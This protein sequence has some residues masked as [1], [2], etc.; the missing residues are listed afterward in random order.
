MNDK[1]RLI[2]LLAKSQS[3][4]KI[5]QLV[6]DDVPTEVIAEINSVSQSEFSKAAQIGITSEFQISMWSGEYAGQEY[7]KIGNDR[8]HV[9]RTYDTGDRR[10][11]LYLEEMP[12]HGTV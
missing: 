9:Y 12:A 2:T 7:V 8:Y 11:E 6:D 3:T 5:G 4:D 10:I 1:T